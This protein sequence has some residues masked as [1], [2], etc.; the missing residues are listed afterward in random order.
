M[1]Q[2]IYS[3]LMVVI[4]LQML[5]GCFNNGPEK[6]YRE[7][8]RREL[9][10]GVRYDS[11]F[12]GIYFGMPYNTFRDHCMKMHVRGEFFEGGLKSGSWV[13]YRM[14]GEM[15]YAAGLNFNPEFRN[16]KLTEVKA[17]I[18]YAAETLKDRHFVQD[19]LLQDALQLMKNWYG[20]SF[21]KVQ[22]PD[23]VK[24]DLYVTVSGNRRITIY[25]DDRN[26]YLVN[27]WFVDLTQLQR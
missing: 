19:S 10:S 16:G 14:Q 2:K 12:K 25:A 1:I 6:R 4:F 17:A 26:K 9:E 3:V 20:H 23:S 7:L 5:M 8:E 21:I 15:K 22:S 27:L 13:E 18:Y 11:L 24:S